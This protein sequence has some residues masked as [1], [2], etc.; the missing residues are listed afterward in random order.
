MQTIVLTGG[1]G[2]VGSSLYPL[3]LEK[4]FRVIIFTRRLRPSTHEHLEYAHW[5][6][7]N[8]KID[9]AALLRADHIIHLAGAGIAD[10]RWT[11][12]RKQIIRDSRILSTR[13]LYNT[14]KEHGH[15]PQAFICAS[16]TGFYGSSQEHSFRESDPPST[17]FI[18]ETCR[19]WET[20]ALRLRDVCDRV[21]MMR[22]GLV[23]SHEGGVLKALRKPFFL[24]LAAIMGNGNQWTSW[25]HLRDLCRLYF[26]AIGNKTWQGPYNAVAPEPVTHQTMVLSLA[27]ILKGKYFVPVHIPSFLLR[28]ALGEMGEE[29]LKSCK[30]S[31]E[32]VKGTGF[33]FSYPTLQDALEALFHQKEKP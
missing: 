33:Q 27:G 20:E 32:K 24:D 4:G 31:A 8:G 3:L 2:L 10:K 9:T 11:E 15:R 29:L 1:T 17:D 19:L 7:D 28:L 25:I 30:A 22:T 6:V 26:S 18:G 23:L 21:V 16:A 5:D 12:R 14:L 13:L